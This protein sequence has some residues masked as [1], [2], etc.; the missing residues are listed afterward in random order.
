[1]TRTQWRRIV[2]HKY[3]AWFTAPQYIPALQRLSLMQQSDPF[4]LITRIRSVELR[5]KVIRG[6]RKVYNYKGPKLP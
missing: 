1:M 4:H 2:V 5:L 3:D 6:H